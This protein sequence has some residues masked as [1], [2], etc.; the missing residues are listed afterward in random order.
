MEPRIQYAKTEDGVNIAYATY[1]EG[2]PLA[3]DDDLFGTTVIRAARIAALADGGEI[4]VSNVVRELVEG[5]GFLFSDRG[6]APLRGF[7]ETVRVYEVNWRD[8]N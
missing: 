2:E 4:F 5:K 3:E 7:E 1:G 6:D 8:E